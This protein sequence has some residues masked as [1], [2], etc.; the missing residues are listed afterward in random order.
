[1][2]HQDWVLRATVTVEPAPHGGV[3]HPG[4][5]SGSAV[6]RVIVAPER[7]AASSRRTRVC[8]VVRTRRASGQ[9]GRRR[10]WFLSRWCD[11][12]CDGSIGLWDSKSRLHMDSNVIPGVI[13]STPIGSYSCVQ[14][15]VENDDDFRTLGQWELNFGHFGGG[16][17]RFHFACACKPS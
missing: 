6:L 11:M 8:H 15:D 14:G 9:F 17:G 13:S 5:V 7:A 3:A 4:W 1:M 12:W 16:Q 10:R 2:A